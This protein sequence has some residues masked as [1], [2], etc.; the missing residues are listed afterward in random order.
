MEKYMENIRKINEN[1]GNIWLMKTAKSRLSNGFMKK[2]SFA[3]ENCD[4]FVVNPL[5]TVFDA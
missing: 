3:D 1:Y 2:D 4:I 5:C